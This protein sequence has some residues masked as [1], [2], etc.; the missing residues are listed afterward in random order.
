MAPTSNK[1]Y[2]LCCNLPHAKYR[3]G[4]ILRY[5]LQDTRCLLR[6]RSDEWP[7]VRKSIFSSLLGATASVSFCDKKFLVRQLVGPVEWQ[8][9]PLSPTVRSAYR[10]YLWDDLM[11]YTQERGF[12]LLQVCHSAETTN[13]TRGRLFKI[14][15]IWRYQS[16]NVGTQLEG[17][18]M[19]VGHAVKSFRRKV[20]S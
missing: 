20:T 18:R 19:H 17:G 2:V 15:V 4:T 7:L 12:H 13:A 3:P 11:A 1:D 6:K 9:V 16:S 5:I 8:H 14:I 10:K